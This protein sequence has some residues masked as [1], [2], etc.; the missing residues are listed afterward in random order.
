MLV[1]FPLKFSKF[2]FLSF[3]RDICISVIL[4][5]NSTISSDFSVNRIH[6][7]RA[8]LKNQTLKT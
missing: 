8:N 3:N 5:K 4:L 6:L 2:Q 1:A 7:E